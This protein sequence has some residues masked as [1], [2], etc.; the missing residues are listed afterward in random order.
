[1]S[2]ASWLI[3]NTEISVKLIAARIYMTGIR[4]RHPIPVDAP[5]CSDLRTIEWFNWCRPLS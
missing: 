4:W 5:A 3:I 1:M 2:E